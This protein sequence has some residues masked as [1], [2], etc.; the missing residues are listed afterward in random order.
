[1][2]ACFQAPNTPAS[3]G[4]CGDPDPNTAGVTDYI[5]PTGYVAKTTDVT[6]AACSTVTECNTNCCQVRPIFIREKLENQL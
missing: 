2:N 5:C 4:T 6:S 3:G 1:M